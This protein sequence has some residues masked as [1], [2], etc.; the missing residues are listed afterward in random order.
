M[1]ADT[2]AA[3][4]AKLSSAFRRAEVLRPCVL[5][6]RNLQLLLGRRGDAREDSR[7]HAALCRLLRGAP[8]RSLPHVRFSLRSRRGRGAEV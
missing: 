3:S 7:V 6:L 2:P 5:L 8:C 4:E 1:C